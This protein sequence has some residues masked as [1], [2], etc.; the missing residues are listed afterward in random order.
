MQWRFSEGGETEMRKLLSPNVGVS[1]IASIH[2]NIFRVVFPLLSTAAV[3]D[4]KEHLID[5]QAIQTDQFEAYSTYVNLIITG[6]TQQ[7]YAETGIASSMRGLE[8][9]SGKRKPC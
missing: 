6:Q 5:E 1:S 7:K 2:A 3:D 4:R 8:R 9:T